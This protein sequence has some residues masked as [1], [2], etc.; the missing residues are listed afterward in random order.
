MNLV[1]YTGKQNYV[2][3]VANTDMVLGVQWMYSIG[4]HSMNYKIPQMSFKSTKGKPIVLKGINI[5]P[6]QLISSNNMRSI[7]RHGDIECLITD[8]RTIVKVSY[9]TKDIKKLFHKH[10]GGFQNTK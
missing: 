5:Y 8:E 10:K 9:M 6:S 7:L 3:N 4:E 2:V 1:E